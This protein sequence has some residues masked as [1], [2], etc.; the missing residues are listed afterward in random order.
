[1]K[2]QFFSDVILLLVI[3]IQL[4]LVLKLA[5]QNEELEQRL[6]S[7]EQNTKL[8]TLRPQQMVFMNEKGEL[9]NVK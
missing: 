3:L 1:M 5:D 7:V 4:S 2:R 6:A 8:L 9:V